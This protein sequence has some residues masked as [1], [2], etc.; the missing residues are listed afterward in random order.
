MESLQKGRPQFISG[1]TSCVYSYLAFQISLTGEHHPGCSRDSGF[2]RDHF[3]WKLVL[4]LSAGRRTE[5][6]VV[7]NIFLAQGSDTL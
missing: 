5:V 2:V 4:C 7:V 1:E 6:M 3:G